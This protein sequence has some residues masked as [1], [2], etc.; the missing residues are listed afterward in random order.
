MLAGSL[1]LLAAFVWILWR[2]H[3]LS[4]LARQRSETLPLTIQTERGAMRLVPAGSFLASEERVPVNLPAFYLSI[5]AVQKGLSFEAAKRFCESAGM[6]LPK[7]I[8]W[9]KAVEEVP[10][11]REWVDDPHRPRRFEL[12]AFQGMLDPPASL[13]EDWSSLR[14]GPGAKR[15]DYTSAP[16]RYASE[17]IAFRCAMAPK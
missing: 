9:E 4:V 3:E 11:L 14:G 6:R 13:D 10:V 2:S 8:E 12:R 1:A 16:V 7:P 15:T 5:E 17:D